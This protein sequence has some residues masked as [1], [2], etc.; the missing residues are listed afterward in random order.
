MIGIRARILHLSD[1][2]FSRST[3]DTLLDELEKLIRQEKPDVLAVTGDLCDHPYPPYMRK[4]WRWLRK[5]R[6]ACESPPAV[7]VV[8]GNHD[9]K[10][11]GNI[12]LRSFSRVPFLAWLASGVETEAE[13]TLWAMFRLSLHSLLPRTRRLDYG[14]SWRRFD[15]LGIAVFCFDSVPPFEM[16]ACGEI[17]PRDLSGFDE[18]LRRGREDSPALDGYFKIALV[19]H[20]PLPTRFVPK[21]RKERLFDSLMVFHNAGMF[22][23]RICECDFQ[24]V[25]HGHRHFAGQA[26]YNAGP[27]TSPQNTVWIVSAGTAAAP[28]LDDPLGHHLNIIDLM[29]DDTIV[30]HSRYFSE[31]ESKARGSGAWVLSP[32]A[33]A[34]SVRAR[35]H[36]ARQGFSAKMIRKQVTITPDGYTLLEVHHLGCRAA[37]SEGLDGRPI[38]LEAPE[39]TYIRGLELVDLEH[40]PPY[41][42]LSISK[43]GLRTVVARHEFGRL[44][45]EF[46]AGF[47]IRL[48]NGHALNAQQSRRKHGEQQVV[49]EYSSLLCDVPCESLRIE[50]AFPEG[51]R[52][53]QPDVEVLFQTWSA[54]SGQSKAWE[55][56]PHHEAERER[57]KGDLKPEPGRI[58]FECHQPIPGF[59]YQLRWRLPETAQIVPPVHAEDR[60]EAGK[61]GLLRI[62]DGAARGAREETARFES[63]TGLLNLLARDIAATLR[64]PESESLELSLAVYDSGTKKLRLVC[65]N[66]GEP[67][68]IQA[69]TFAPGEGCAG[70]AFEKARVVLYHPR[71]DSVGYFISS[72]EWDAGKDVAAAGDSAARN[73]RVLLCIPWVTPENIMLGV[74]SLGSRRP[75]TQL[76]RL[77]DEPPADL[78]NHLKSLALLTGMVAG[79]ILEEARM[80]H[81]TNLGS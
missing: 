74:V 68:R 62:L 36:M 39:P 78:D 80:W 19:H 45:K 31:V 32:L 76:A 7:L 49:W 66:N 59:I 41:Q 24:M 3:P 40:S 48:I 73:E 47:H 75:D 4:A 63:S 65:A 9:Y 18:T 21:K 1:L 53:E 79:A 15:K 61:A 2:H 16:F 26:R 10:W 28:E 5:V 12:G 11:W 22:L 23:K 42:H 43:A 14:V 38:A 20:H 54:E 46:S 57:V 58:V 30:F 60:V 69:R 72:Q 44:E 55:E 70:F 34:R 56:L 51:I 77:F 8:P 37:N 35:R 52:Y 29:E 27:E 64:F 50:V 25:L 71:R 67:R 13:P 6:L 17:S 81:V 33:E